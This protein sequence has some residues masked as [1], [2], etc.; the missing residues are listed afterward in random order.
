MSFN[1]LVA[2]AA[3][4]LCWYAVPAQAQ[5]VKLRFH[6]GLVTLTTQ[7]APLRTILAE[8][9]RLGGT[10]IVNAER[11]TGAPLTLELNAVPEQQAL[12]ILLRSVS[13]YMAAAR[14]AGSAGA[15][16]YDRILILPTSVG[17]RNPTPPT[18]GFQQG[19][20][21]VPPVLRRP[22]QIVP[23]PEP[24]DE[25]EPEEEDLV[26]PPVVQP[27]PGIVPRPQPFPVGP[28]GIPTPNVE[29]DDDPTIQPTPTTTPGNPFGLPAGATSRPGVITPVPQQQPPR[30]TQPDPEP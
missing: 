20:G 22:P 26:V 4:L 14:A 30:R 24:E 8:W 23:Q 12:D 15:S 16:V 1:R 6:D 13:G 10:T 18:P 11:V 5:A 28:P 3:I 25:P 2:A 7:N 17:P 21:G 9:A 27:G 29:P 19:R